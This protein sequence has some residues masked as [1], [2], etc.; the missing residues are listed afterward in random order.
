MMLM[1]QQPDQAMCG[2]E[3]EA[4]APMQWVVGPR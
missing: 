1:W 3:E 2:E 4:H